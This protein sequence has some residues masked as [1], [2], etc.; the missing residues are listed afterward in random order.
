MFDTDSTGTI[1]QSE[2]VVILQRGQGA[3]VFSVEEATQMAQQAIEQFDVNGD[4]TLQ[5]DEFVGWWRRNMQGDE[6]TNRIREA[7]LQRLFG[8]LDKDKSGYLDM[9][10]FLAMSQAEA[11]KD[12][13]PLLF[14]HIDGIGNADGKVSLD[15]WLVSP[16]REMGKDLSDEEYVKQM[17]NIASYLKEK[18]PHLFDTEHWENAIM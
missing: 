7:L 9:K 11:D 6:G 5:Y 4:G 17:E 10:E 12:K 15:D 2:L 13:L 8:A 3:S 16:M 1:S 18:E 14:K